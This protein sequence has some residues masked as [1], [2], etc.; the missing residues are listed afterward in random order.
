MCNY[1]IIVFYYKNSFFLS[2][3][4][5]RA[6]LAVLLWSRFRQVVWMPNDILLS[7]P[8]TAWK[9]L[10]AGVGDMK[11]GHNRFHLH[12]CFGKMADAYSQKINNGTQKSALEGCSRAL[13][14]ADETRTRD[15]MRDR[16]VF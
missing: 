3:C 6:M 7:L 2:I 1:I 4:K 15:P 11:A 8:A 9:R 5:I 12:L 13:C 10:V 16:H 14:G